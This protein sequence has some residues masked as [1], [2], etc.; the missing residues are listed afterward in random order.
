MNV[1]TIELVIKADVIILTAAT[2]E[3]S[4]EFHW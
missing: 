2:S 1:V 4:G 3:G